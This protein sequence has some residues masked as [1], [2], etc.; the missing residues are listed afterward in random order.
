MNIEI[1]D[2]SDITSQEQVFGRTKGEGAPLSGT[3]E[4]DTPDFGKT[5]AGTPVIPPTSHVALAAP[6][7]N[8]GI[9]I[10]RRGFN[11]TDGINELG[12]L[13]AGLLLIAYMNDQDHF[14]KLQTKLGGSDKLN[15][16]IAHIGS[17]IFAPSSLKR[18][19]SKKRLACST[20]KRVTS[21]ME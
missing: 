2:S 9:R 10:L 16:Y 4:F 7:N 20:V 18:S 21:S 14:V 6:E 11:Y 12:F 3:K 5:V 17:A 8:N 1:W 13:D 15:E 19:C